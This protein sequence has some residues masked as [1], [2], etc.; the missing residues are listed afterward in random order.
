MRARGLTTEVSILN[1]AN[2]M[3]KCASAL[4]NAC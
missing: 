2:H 4:C 3:H 1:Q